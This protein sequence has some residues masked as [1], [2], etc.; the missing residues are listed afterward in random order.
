VRAAERA[1]KESRRVAE[2]TVGAQYYLGRRDDSDAMRDVIEDLFSQARCPGR[3]QE[4][5]IDRMALVY[6]H[7]RRGKVREARGEGTGKKV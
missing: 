6:I 3:M 2:R 1:S 7:E 4:P 5:T